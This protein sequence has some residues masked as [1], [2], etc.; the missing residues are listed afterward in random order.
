[1]KTRILLIAV[2]T[3]I[4]APVLWARS[5]QRD[6][7]DVNNDGVR[8]KLLEKE[9]GGSSRFTDITILSGKRVIFKTDQPFCGDYADGYLCDKNQLVVW[10]VDTQ[11]TL[12]ERTKWDPQYYSIYWYQYSKKDGRYIQTREAFT[13]RKYSTSTARITLSSLIKNQK[14]SDFVTSKSASFLLGVKAYVAKKYNRPL[15]TIEDSHYDDDESGRI[16]Y[17]KLKG[18][19][20]HNVIVTISRTGEIASHLTEI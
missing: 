15:I 20:T 10:K 8:E 11:S 12:E 3:L 6:I 19:T 16:F 2:M 9:F 7:G 5:G 17:V 1:M 13:K 14:I 4:L 18:M